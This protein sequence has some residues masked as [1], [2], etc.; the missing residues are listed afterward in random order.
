MDTHDLDA[1]FKHQAI[2]GTL[3]VQG[4]SV[5][6]LMEDGIHELPHGRQ[7]T[8]VPVIELEF[9]H[10]HADE[11]APESHRDT[12]E[13]ASNPQS[14]EKAKKEESSGTDRPEQQSN[15]GSPDAGS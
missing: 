3:D 9:S 10:S 12:Q 11:P 5:A 7:H 1:P 2:D 13:S 8:S 4:R 14:E 15:D 6:L